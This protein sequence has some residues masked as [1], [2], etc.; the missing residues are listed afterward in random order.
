MRAT[1]AS[2]RHRLVVGALLGGCLGFTPP[3]ARAQEP[4]APDAVPAATITPGMTRDEV[5]TQLGR[6]RGETH[7]GSFTYLFY[8]NGCAVKCGMDDVVVFENN[9]VTDAIFRS[10]NRTF[11]GARAPAQTLAPAPPPVRGAAS[12]LR[13]STRED[14]AQRGGIVFAP[15]NPIQPPPRY[16]RIVPTHADSARGASMGTPASASTPSDTT[17]ISPH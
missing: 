6:P 11:T 4:Q 1:S 12:P 10:P 2:V 13:A 17:S 14:S 8:D 7:T 16:V 3:A 9:A 5:M 15:R